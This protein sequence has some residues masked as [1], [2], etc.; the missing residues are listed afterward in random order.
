MLFLWKNFAYSHFLA[1]RCEMHVTD[2]EPTMKSF[3][4]SKLPVLIPV[5]QGS[6]TSLRAYF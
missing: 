1:L 6:A 4:S 2:D 3:I 5:E